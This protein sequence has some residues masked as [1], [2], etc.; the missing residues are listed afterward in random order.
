MK[1]DIPGYIGL[2]F[3]GVNFVAAGDVITQI[4]S[5]V[6]AAV[7]AL[8]IIIAWGMRIYKT[9][10][11]W[12]DKKITTEQAVDELKQIGEEIKNHDTRTDK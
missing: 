7:C 2:F 9:V 1:Y 10:K 5:V 4:I 8:S 3:A 6:S 12:I 11:K